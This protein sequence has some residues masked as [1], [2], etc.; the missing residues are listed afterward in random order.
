M[1]KSEYCIGVDLGGTN[2]AVG[3]VEVNSGKIINK[4]SV[5]TNAPRPVE[6][7]A[8]DIIS[9]CQ[10][11]CAIE[12]IPFSSLA[13]LGVATPGIISE[14]VI[15]SATNLGWTNAPLKRIL[16]EKTSLTVYLSNDANAAA[17]AEATR[18]SG[19][20]A[21]SLV[22]FTIGTGVGG[23]IVFDGKIWEGANGFAGEMGHFVIEHNGR[24]CGC[25]RRGCIESYCSATALVKSTKRA[26]LENRDSLLWKAAPQ[27]SDVNGK[28]VFSAMEMGDAC[29][30]AV[31]DEFVSYLA[32]GVSNVINLFQPEVVCIGG[33]I[34]REGDTLI[35]P[36]SE[37][38]L[39]TSLSVSGKRTR[40]VAAEF[41]NDAGIIGA[42]FLGLQTR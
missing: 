6:E 16:E 8:E 34:S 28:T 10:K 2:V 9:V 32:T 22:A 42:A 17:Y 4:K 18:G 36:L 19:R 27:V 25:G 26:M 29:A 23:G 31:F 12:K 3:I 13:W 41:K 1:K 21:S 40:I 39:K 33:G 20:G 11:L 35:K 30:K 14:G 37:L 7:I 5:K 15:V 24:E 38:V